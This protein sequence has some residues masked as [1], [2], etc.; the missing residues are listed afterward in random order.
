MYKQKFTVVFTYV[1]NCTS[2]KSKND[3]DFK[4]TG[5]SYHKY[6]LFEI[7]SVKAACVLVYVL[8]FKIKKI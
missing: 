6:L 5:E 8:V 1:N 7:L 2:N 4:K 3:R